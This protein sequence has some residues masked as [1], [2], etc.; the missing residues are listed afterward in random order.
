M[1]CRGIPAKH[2][3]FETFAEQLSLYLINRGWEVTVYCQENDQK[4]LREDAW[5]VV[6]L[7]R[8]SPK[9]HGAFGT[10]LFD[11]KSTRHTLQEQGLKLTL[12]YNTALFT[13]LYRFKGQNSLINMDGVEWRRAKWS[14]IEK[15][16]L[17]LNERLGC[18]FASHLI[19][20]NPEIKSHLATRVN[21]S[22]ITTIPYCSDVINDAD[23][24]ILQDYGLVRSGYALIIA[25][26]EPEN[27]IWEI[28]SAFSTKR[29]GY[30][31][32]VLGNYDADQSP[33][34]RRVK[35]ASSDEVRY[36]GA[37]YDKRV[38]N[39]LRYFARLYC[40]GHRVGG[41]NPSLVESLGAGN[42]VLAHDNKF[43]RWV[44]G[45]E[46]PYFK[47]EN[48][49]LLQLDRLLDNDSELERL[50]AISRERHRMMFMCE[51]VLR[52]YETLLAL[53][54]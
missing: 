11:W 34:H 36:L 13:L 17:Y 23:A 35:D 31:L 4:E 33:Y 42:P 28:I 1:G 2:G 9:F 39:A 52:S 8:I 26:P 41:T 7:V 19:A 51:N 54:I 49:C 47:D 32:V 16:W 27:S 5:K 53:W 12:G 15:S 20:D 43:N 37:V 30:P 44:C 45:S 22:K 50:R 24:S 18:L 46:M 10:I 29:R 6:R 48:D 38:V 40:H 21:P 25:R 3:G 14:A